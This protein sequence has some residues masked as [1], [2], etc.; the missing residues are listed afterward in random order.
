MSNN[1]QRPGIVAVVFRCEHWTAMARDAALTAT[2]WLGLWEPPVPPCASVSL[3][4]S[5]STGLGLWF[6]PSVSHSVV[7]VEA[8]G[9]PP[10]KVPLTFTGPADC[11]GRSICGDERPLPS[12]SF[13]WSC[14]NIT[15]CQSNHTKEFEVTCRAHS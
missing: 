14:F 2:R 13:L 5:R 12:H 10:L 3:W 7:P 11:E 1:T 9:L 6:M 8:G 4:R 15:G